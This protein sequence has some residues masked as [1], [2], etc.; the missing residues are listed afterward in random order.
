MIRGPLFQQSSKV[1][2]RDHGVLRNVTLKAALDLP[3]SYL[4]RPTRGPYDFHDATSREMNRVLRNF[5]A[6]SP[7]PYDDTGCRGRCSTTIKVRYD[8][9]L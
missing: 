6:R 8:K 4:L 1:S 2:L 9:M 7:I 5:S 3:S